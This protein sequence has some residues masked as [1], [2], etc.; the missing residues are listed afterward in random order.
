VAGREVRHCIGLFAPRAHLEHPQIVSYPGEAHRR[1]GCA[2]AGF[3]L[4]A[5]RGTHSIWRP[6]VS[7]TNRLRLCVPS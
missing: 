4:G 3:D 1:P 5:D 2:Q 7:Q 6:I